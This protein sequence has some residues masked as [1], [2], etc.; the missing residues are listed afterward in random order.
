M[1]PWLGKNDKEMYWQYNAGKSTTAGS[2]IRILKNKNYKYMTSVSKNV[3][4]DKLDDI[5]DKYNDT[6]HIT[7]KIKPVEVKSNTYN[8]CSKVVKKLMIKI[9]NLKW[10][11]ML[12]YQNIIIFLKKFTLQIDLKKFLWWRKLKVLCC[13]HMLLIILKKKLLECFAKNN[14]KKQ[15]KKSLEL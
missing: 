9:L 10:V 6:Y 5:V 12:E 8:D 2:F 4:I 14:C 11:I 13:G 7:I 3:Y 15:I 1:K